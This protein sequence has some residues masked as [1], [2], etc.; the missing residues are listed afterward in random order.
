MLP[1]YL[2]YS[3]ALRW[4]WKE[5]EKKKL[6][7]GKLCKSEKNNSEFIKQHQELFKYQVQEELWIRK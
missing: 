2:L 4:T 3:S 7:N 5:V 6:H 1:E